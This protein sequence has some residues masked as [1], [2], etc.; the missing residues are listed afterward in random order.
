MHRCRTVAQISLILSVLNLVLAAP[1]LVQEIHEARRDEMVVAEDVAAVPKWSRMEAPDPDLSPDAS[2]HA[3]AFPERAS[4][5]EASM[6]SGYYP[7]PPLSPGSP[8][9]GSRYLWLL[10]RPQLLGLQP[11][12]SLH[13]SASTHPSSLGP[14]EIPLPELQGLALEDIPSSPGSPPSRWQGLIDPAPIPHPHPP[15]PVPHTSS[16]GS[17]APSRQLM[18]SDWLPT[19]TYYSLPHRPSPWHNSDGSMPSLESIS[20]ELQPSHDPMPEELAPLHHLASDE[21]MPSLE[22][23][24]ESQPSHDPLPEELAPLHHSALDGSMP[25]L[26]SISGGSEP[27]RDPMPEGLAPSY[28][29]AS[30]GSMPSLESISGGSGPLHDPMPEGLAPSHHLTSVTSDGSP[31]PDNAEFFNKN[32]MKKFKIVAGMI[33]IG[34]IIAGSIA[35]SQIKHRDYQDTSTKSDLT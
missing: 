23:S 21:S 30:D 2:P 19:E 28:H 6:S 12:A 22:I 8:D 29:S 4:P 31:P 35:G 14:P 15:V 10:D 24:G 32:M 26:E 9:S 11:P 3:M 27:S 1:I 18:W 16:S 34:S 33:I 5:S 20:G 7:S 13:E 17:S 25:S